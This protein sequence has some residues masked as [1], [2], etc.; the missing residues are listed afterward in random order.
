M[1][2][3][4]GNALEDNQ[5]LFILQEH[6]DFKP[7]AT[8]DYSLIGNPKY[9][10][11]IQGPK[12]FLPDYV[13]DP[14]PYLVKPISVPKDLTQEAKEQIAGESG[15]VVIQEQ[16]GRGDDEDDA[17]TVDSAATTDQPAGAPVTGAETSS[18]ADEDIS[19]LLVRERDTFL[20]AAASSA[21]APSGGTV[22]FSPTASSEDSEPE[23]SSS[24][25]EDL[26]VS[27]LLEQLLAAQKKKK[28]PKER[29][30]SV[31]LK[32]KPDQRK[33]VKRKTEVTESNSNGRKAASKRSQL[34][35]FADS[36]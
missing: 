26:P 7:S 3:F 35:Y 15:R 31:S 8:T 2:P 23:V 19:S 10:S 36:D 18:A 21:T 14:N 22:T 30:K 5:D 25:G 16:V 9:S 6:K 32:K 27:E 34:L 17:G 12:F 1:L 33:P 20:E 29:V 24:S 11:V 4:F 13:S 28:R